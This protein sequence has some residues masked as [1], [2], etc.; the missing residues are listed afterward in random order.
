M[1][2]FLKDMNAFLGNIEGF[3]KNIQAFLHIAHDGALHLANQ[4]EKHVL[5]EKVESDC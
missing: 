5:L 4:L 1:N 2:A 3:F